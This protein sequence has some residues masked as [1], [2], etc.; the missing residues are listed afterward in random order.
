VYEHVYETV[1]IDGASEEVRA[2]AVA[3]A[4]VAG[5]FDVTH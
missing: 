2:T 5:A 3:K 4:T 1:D